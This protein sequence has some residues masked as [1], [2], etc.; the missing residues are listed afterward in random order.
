MQEVKK[1]ERKNCQIISADFV[2]LKRT[3]LYLVH[4]LI[5]KNENRKSRLFHIV[6]ITA[7]RKST[8]TLGVD[9][10]NFGLEKNFNCFFQCIQIASQVKFILGLNWGRNLN[11]KFKFVDSIF[12]YV[13]QGDFFII[14]GVNCRLEFHNKFGINFFLYPLLN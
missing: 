12:Q 6:Q 3:E 4:D 8:K 11:K 2:L 5:P 7:H 13:I 1:M 9:K 10:T 14:L